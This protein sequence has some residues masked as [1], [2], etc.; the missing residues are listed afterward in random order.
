MKGGAVGSAVGSVQILFDAGSAT[1]LSDRQLLE[2]FLARQGP[3]AELAFGALV[4]HHG[5]MVWNVCR[6]VLADSHAA[7]DAFQATFLIL[8][9]KAN[10]IRRRETLGPWLHGV[11]RRVAVRAK[12]N[13]ARQRNRECRGAEP[14][15][16]GVSPLVRQEE[17]NALHQEIDRLPEKYRAV[18]VLY[19]LEG[20]THAEA[21]QL[22]KCP[23]GTV[24][25]RASRARELL[26]G[27]L[28][29]RGVALSAALF[30]M[31]SGDSGARAAVPAGLAESTIK[32]AIHVT[33]GHAIEAGAVPAAVE[34]LTQGV[35]R[36]MNMTKLS[37]FAVGALATGIA[38][39]WTA[40]FA[41]GQQPAEQKPR[42]GA[43]AS[44]DEAA[45]T[46]KARR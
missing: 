5:P 38:T 40:F 11:A 2:Q 9:H 4:A 34:K 19:H 39:S 33:A 28:T 31:T 42:P 21:A 8:V 7:E 23:A 37:I 1:G 16:A 26:R 27:R 20:R 36:T 12:A 43:A 46:Q 24:S 41:I 32:A 13:M 30:G 22:L 29:R 45:K 35:I 44:A 6:G 25:V 17:I 18:I 14:M 3:L 15:A 10:S